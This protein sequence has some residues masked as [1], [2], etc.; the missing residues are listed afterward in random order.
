MALTVAAID[1]IPAHLATIP[2]KDDTPRELTRQDAT[3][4]NGG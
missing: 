1:A 4:Q 3:A 2:Q